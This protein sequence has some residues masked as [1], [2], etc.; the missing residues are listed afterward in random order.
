MTNHPMLKYIQQKNIDFKMLEEILKPC[1]KSNQYTNGGPVKKLLEKKLESILKIDKDRAVLCTNNGTAALQALYFFLKQKNKDLKIVTPAFTFPSAVVG[2]D[3]VD[4]LDIDHETYTIPFNIETINKYDVFVITNLFGTYPSNILQWV[5]WCKKLNK[6]LIFDNASSPLSAVNGVNICNL[7]DFSFGSLHHTKSI[8]F[9]E[10]GF[11]VLPKKLYNQFEQ[12][13]CFGFRQRSL[14]RMFQK[15]SSNLKMSDVAAASILQN[16][17]RYDINKH[18]ENQALLINE[19]ENI[20]GLEV[21]NY[22][23]GVVYGNMPIVYEKAMD[24]G[25]FRANNIEVQKYY[26]PLEPYENSLSLFDRMINI[27]LY[28]DM[29]QQDIQRIIEVVKESLL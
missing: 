20:S 22:S 7:G 3:N 9:G 25:I 10:G 15:N 18:I 16:I 6:T 26:Y 12:I 27:P 8:G 13:L 23:D 14:K 24:I 4:I 28:A 2:V 17:E 21:F 5:E 11:I 29:N 19:L 1:E